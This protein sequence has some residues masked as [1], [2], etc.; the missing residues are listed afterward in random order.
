M[1]R[2]VL[3]AVIF[4]LIA[5]SGRSFAQGVTVLGTVADESKGVLPGVTVTATAVDTGRQF[6]D[7]TS[8][9]GEYRLVGLLAGGYQLIAELSG[10]ASTRI[11]RVD[12]L[13]GQNAT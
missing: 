7:V 11:D 9:K 2:R 5:G 3:G 6:T 13:V 1:W 12:L 4:A 8:E 10:F